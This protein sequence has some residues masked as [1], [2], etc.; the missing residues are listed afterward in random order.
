VARAFD[1]LYE[2]HQTADYDNATEWTRVEVLETV[3]IAE[4]AF[5]SWTAI[6]GRDIANDY[7]LSLFVKER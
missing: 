3:Q 7:L 5:A 2:A 1:N 6:R 4:Q